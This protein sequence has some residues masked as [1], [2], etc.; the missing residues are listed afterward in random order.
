MKRNIIISLLMAG[1]VLFFTFGCE[2]STKVNNPD[3]DNPEGNNQTPTGQEE[4]KSTLNITLAATSTLKSMDS[5]N[6]VN[7]EIQQISFHTS[8]DTA[9]G[10]TTA[11]WYDLETIPGI[12]NLMDFVIDD[13]LVA[14]DSL[15]EPQTI[16]QIRLIL[17]DSNTVMVDSVLYDLFT[18]SA[19]NSGIKI[20]VHTQMV[21]D[22]TYVIMLDFDPEQSVKQLGNGK[23]K[24][25]PVIQAIVNP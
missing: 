17:G 8:G 5:I 16:S 25:Q 24:L 2:K 3:A 6:A 21:P 18:P 7:L 19:Q 10:D 13:T 20:Q 23:Y 1:I 14:F 9:S 12:Y 11:G 22:S 15:V 4:S